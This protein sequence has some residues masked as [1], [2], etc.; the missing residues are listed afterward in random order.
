MSDSAPIPRRALQSPCPVLRAQPEERP[1]LAAFASSTGHEGC[2]HRTGRETAEK[3]ACT[4][5]LHILA[6][7]RVAT[8][9]CC[10]LVLCFGRSPKKGLHWQ[11]SLQTQN[12]RAGANQSRNRIIDCLS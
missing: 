5:P 3:V 9:R 1:P 6:V 11:P 7:F 12:E 10:L 2:Q 4:Y 8:L